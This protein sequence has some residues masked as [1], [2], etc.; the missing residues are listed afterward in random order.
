VQFFSFFFDRALD[1]ANNFLHGS[2]PYRTEFLQK[3]AQRPELTGRF[4]RFMVRLNAVLLLALIV[5]GG[6][7][8]LK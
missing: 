7:C 8:V 4:D 5:A 1:S 2:I 3:L 6:W